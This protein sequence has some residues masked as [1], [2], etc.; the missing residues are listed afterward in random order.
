MHLRN[1]DGTLFSPAWSRRAVEY[2]SGTGRTWEVAENMAGLMREAGF[3]DVGERRF[4]WPVGGASEV[5]RWNLGR[6]YVM[7]FFILSFG[8]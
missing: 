3:V 6:W 2:G 7:S 1:P 4:R 5:G 8:L